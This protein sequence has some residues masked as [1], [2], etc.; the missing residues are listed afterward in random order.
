MQGDT[1]LIP[2]PEDLSHALEELKPEHHSLLSLWSGALEEA[3]TTEP[4]HLAWAR[5]PRAWAPH[6]SHMSA[7]LSTE[8]KVAPARCI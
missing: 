8:T 2:D 3:A 7:S 4:T 1:C 6:S 5:H